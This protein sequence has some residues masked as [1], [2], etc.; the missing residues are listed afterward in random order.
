MKQ[1]ST[2]NRLYTRP[3]LTK[4]LKTPNELSFDEPVNPLLKTPLENGQ[5][6]QTQLKPTKRQTHIDE[7]KAGQE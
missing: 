1:K 4:G 6:E 5:E 3:L 7:Q 2:V